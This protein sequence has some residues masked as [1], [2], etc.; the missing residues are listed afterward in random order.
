[1]T[2]GQVSIKRNPR[3]GLIIILAVVVP[4]WCVVAWAVL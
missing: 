3:L 2:S 1:M 4:F